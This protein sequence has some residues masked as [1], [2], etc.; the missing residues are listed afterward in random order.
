MLTPV[1]AQIGRHEI[2]SED[3]I[4]ENSKIGWTHHTWNPWCGCNKVSAACENCYIAQIMHYS[5]REPFRGPIR[6]SNATWRKPF[7]WNRKAARLGQRC[8][9]FTC[10]MSDFFHAKADRWRDEAWNVIRE[11]KN[12]DWLILTKRPDRIARCLPEDWGEGW[13][14]VW[15]GV[16]VENHDWTKRMDAL[17]EIPAVVRF[18][19]A[20][21]LLGPLDLTPWLDRVDWVIAGCEKAGRQKRRKMDIDWVRDLRDQCDEKKVA[22]FFK[23]YYR[24]TTICHDG[25][26]D[27]VVRQSWP[28]GCGQHSLAGS[29]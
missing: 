22:F 11:C 2:F 12:L 26:L 18:I 23:Q 1:L 28:I 10:S 15:L 16:T 25:E 27:G 13:P 4:M 6:T 8:R 17:T 19:S 29:E 24:E 3:R 21:P 9:I 5:G 7:S 14:H 20:E